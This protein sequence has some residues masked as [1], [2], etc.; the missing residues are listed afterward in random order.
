LRAVPHLARN[1][2]ADD[3]HGPLR[4]H[5]W[6]SADV[7]DLG[8][9]WERNR[10]HLSPTQP[11]RDES[12]WTVE[13]QRQRFERAAHDIAV[14]RMFPFLVR[15]DSAL[16]AEVTLSDVTRG[17]FCSS[18]LG[19]S[20]DGARLRRGIASWAVEAVVGIA[21]TDLS[22]HR[23]QAATMVDNVA[24][25]RVLHRC[26][27]DRIGVADGYLAIDGKWADHVLWQ[28]INAELAPISPG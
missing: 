15:E 26:G 23:L 24:S 12:F 25:Q 28:R 5:P 13:G 22:L 4:I 19:Y 18:N 6:S 14:G 9:Y 1:G 17:A 2:E 3:R 16:V 8:V 11:Q 20:V 10:A 27:F 7:E 21:F